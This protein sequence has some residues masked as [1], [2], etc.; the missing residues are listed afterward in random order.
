[1]AEALAWCK[2]VLLILRVFFVFS[3]LSLGGSSLLTLPD[4]SWLIFWGGGETKTVRA[5]KYSDIFP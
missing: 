2:S 5:A 4:F 1:M 3:A